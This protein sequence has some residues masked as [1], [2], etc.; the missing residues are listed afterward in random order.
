MHHSAVE[1]IA[2]DCF[3]KEKTK[4]KTPLPKQNKPQHINMFEKVRYFSLG[5]DLVV[6]LKY[7]SDIISV[8]NA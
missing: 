7:G 8:P 4:T 1:C 2:I 6:V 3:R 5:I